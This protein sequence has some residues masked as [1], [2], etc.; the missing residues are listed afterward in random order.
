MLLHPPAKLNRFL[1]IVGRRADGYHLLQTAF[2]LVDWCDELRI[3][4]R[5]DGVIERIGGP[6]GVAA[7]D[8]LAVRA[9]RMLQ[10]LAAAGAGCTIELIKHIPGGAGLGGGSADAAAVLL[11]L[12][13]LWDLR[14]A[15]QRLAGIGLRL[16]ADVPVFL[17]QQP[18]F[19]EGVGE[20]LSPLP[21]VQRHYAIVWPGVALATGP[22]FAH[23]QLRRD[24]AP[25]SPADYL[26]GHA[27]DN[28]FEPV[29]AALA[30]AVAEALAWLRARFGHAR[31]TGSGSAVY[32]QA[33]D[34][35]S[36]QAGLQGAPVNWSCRAASSLA[37]WFD[38]VANETGK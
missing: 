24:R 15:A 20:I 12:D 8:D 7:E 13:R 19:A 35:A 5:A 9:A 23:P 26:A 16:G 33:A 25:I 2:E 38:K 30:P 22:M 4:T 28:A 34:Y 32:A 27:V 6:P 37:N 14:L 21:F 10:P 29:A 31:L 17:G 1:H 3:E 36:A 11:A 18:A